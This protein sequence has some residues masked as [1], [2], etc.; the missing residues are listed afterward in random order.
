MAK[1]MPFHAHPKTLRAKLA[2]SSAYD[3]AAYT[4]IALDRR[5]IATSIIAITGSNEQLTW[6]ADVSAA[7]VFFSGSSFDRLPNVT[8]TEGNVNTMMISPP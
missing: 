6:V 2:L 3:L 1:A 8:L 7:A 4:R 5:T